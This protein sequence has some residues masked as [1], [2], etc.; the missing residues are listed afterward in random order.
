M[1][2]TLTAEKMMGFLY[3]LPDQF[4]KSLELNYPFAEK[5]QKSYRNI[6]VSGLGGSAIGGDILRTYALP[7]ASLPVVVNRDYNVPAFVH[8]NTLFIAVSY[9]G[10]TEETLSSYQQARDKGADVVCLTS[11]GKLAQ[12]ATEDGFSIIKVP[13]DLVPRAA[14]GYLF[15][16]LA[17]FLEQVGILSGVREEI[18]ETVQVLQALREDLNPHILAPQNLARAI[19]EKIKD[20]IPVIWGSSGVSEVAAL[21]WKAQINEN[22]K[23]PAYYNVFPELNHNEIVGFEVPKELIRQMVLVI[24]RDSGDHERIKK[25]LQITTDI[26]RD[27]V[28]HI[29]EVPSQ[30]T[31]YLARFYSLVYVGDYASAYLALEYGLNPTPVQVIDF[32][33]AELAKE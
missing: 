13:G 22:A 24:L 31:S 30:G 7:R 9:S 2:Q 23:A 32:L 4:H 27:R 33:K 6:V 28:K 14:T 17:L 29:I 15:A 16:P 11:G 19:A 18:V 21:R 12:M 8:Q 3:E 20:S 1:S 26:I 25:R 5:Y 10:N